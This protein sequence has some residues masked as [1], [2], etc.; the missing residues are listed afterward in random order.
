VV[1]CRDAAVAQSD[2]WRK[3]VHR[4]P[5]LVSAFE[6]AYFLAERLALVEIG[7][8]DRAYLDPLDWAAHWDA[9]HHHHGL[10]LLEAE[11][12]HVFTAESSHSP[13]LVKATITTSIQYCERTASC[14]ER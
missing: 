14:V 13:R 9:L 4:A 5:E 2:V 7:F 8:A 3:R 10:S 1:A 11:R 12:C 6:A